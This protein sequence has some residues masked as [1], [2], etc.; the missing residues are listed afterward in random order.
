MSEPMD[1]GLGLGLGFILLHIR[2]LRYSTRSTLAVHIDL[3]KS[4]PKTSWGRPTGKLHT[5]WSIRFPYS[6]G[7]F[8]I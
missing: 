3:S 1:I 6:D 4:R 2:S 7:R 5:T 8:R